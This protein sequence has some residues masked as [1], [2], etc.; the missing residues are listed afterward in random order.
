MD[1]NRA[2]HA[3]INPMWVCEGTS[4][5]ISYIWLSISGPGGHIVE[6]TASH[7]EIAPVAMH[8]VKIYLPLSQVTADI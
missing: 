5:T 6:V 7:S 4:A 1:N 8:I 2:Y 3:V